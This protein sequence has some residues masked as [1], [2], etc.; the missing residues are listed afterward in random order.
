MHN[1]KK[2]CRCTLKGTTPLRLK[3]GTFLLPFF[4]WLPFENPR[5]SSTAIYKTKKKKLISG[6]RKSQE[7]FQV[8]YCIICMYVCV[9][10]SRTTLLLLN[11]SCGATRCT[12]R[13]RHNQDHHTESHSVHQ[14]KTGLQEGENRDNESGTI[15]YSTGTSVRVARI[16]FFTSCCCCTTLTMYQK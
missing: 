9:W 16:D 3:R 10:E 8:S 15:K 4:F 6:L 11:S 14:R 2:T 5:D 13:N 7:R 12:S 1:L